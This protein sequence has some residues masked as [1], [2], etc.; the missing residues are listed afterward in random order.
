M[1]MVPSFLGSAKVTSVYVPY[2]SDETDEEK[3]VLFGAEKFTAAGF[4][5]PDTIDGENGEMELDGNPQQYFAF[6][7][8][9]AA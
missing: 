1:N 9:M 5:L 8:K 7:K 4:T 2:V 6:T 3:L